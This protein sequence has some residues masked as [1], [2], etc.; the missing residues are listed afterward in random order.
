V[1][2]ITV[3]GAS[4]DDKEDDENVD[5]GEDVGEDGRRPD[6]ETQEDCSKIAR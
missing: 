1:Q 3:N 2:H 5:E 6:A 4:D